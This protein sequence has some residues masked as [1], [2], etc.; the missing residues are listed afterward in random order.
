MSME[1]VWLDYD[2]IVIGSGGAGSAAAHAASGAGASVLVVAKDPIGCSDSK[3]A[4]GIVAV[5]AVADDNDSHEAL[6]DNLRLAGGDLPTPEITQAFAEDS[7]DAYDWLRRQGVRPRIDDERG[8]PRALPIP[9]GG[10][11]HRRSVGHDNGGLS[12]GHAVWNAIVQGAGIDYLE[13]A[14]FLDIV[15]ASESDGSAVVGGLVYDAG[16][17]RFLVVRA[18]AIVVAAGGLSTL[19]F[20]NTDTMRGNTGDSFALAARAGAELVDMEQVQFLPFCL[21]APPSYEG[22]LAGEPATAGY[23]GV[24]RDAGGK[25]ILD[26]VMLRTRAECSAAIVKA[27]E[28]GRGTER[29]GCYLDLTAN[30]KAERSGVYYRNFLETAVSGVMVTVRQALGRA[31]AECREQWEVRPGAH[32]SMG[33]IRVDEFGSAISIESR[34]RIKGLFAAGQAMGGVFGANRLGSTSLSEGPIFGARAGR[35]AAGLSRK[36]K[37]V[38]TEAEN[39]AFERRLSHYCGLLGQPG[40][41][42][43]SGLIKE[44]QKAA[45]KGIG[46]ARTRAGIEKFMRQSANFRRDAKKIAISDE[47]LWNQSLI[48]YVEFI[49]MLDTADVVAISALEREDS[50]GA[51]IRLDGGTTSVLFE[52]A[53]SLFAYFDEEMNFRVGRL[54]RPPTPWKRVLIHVLR[55]RKRKLGMK[56]LRLLP[57]FL[58]DR[59]LEKRYHAVMGDVEL[60]H[61]KP[62]SVKVPQEIERE[63]A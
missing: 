55:D 58:Q 3:I 47:G 53:Y 63:A 21:T 20:P 40:E 29:D 23:L 11:T 1:T 60:D 48:D 49:N 25:L 31:A 56:F 61:V 27:V 28:D 45:W 22:L 16:T 43:G 52:K 54:S 10:H 42:T 50:L 46:P 5:R 7:E 26:S 8:T 35:A 4:E 57:V 2:V 32:Y 59:I 17:G 36:A 13:D 24:L 51:H 19:Y 62:E 44:L 9:L 33:G 38:L 34:A 41:K 15:T 12:I 37:A 39:D 30:V 6:A 14:W 18:P